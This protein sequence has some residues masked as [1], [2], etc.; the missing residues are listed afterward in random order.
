VAQIGGTMG[1]LATMGVPS[2]IVTPDK[3]GEGFAAPQPDLAWNLPVPSHTVVN[4]DLP[5]LIVIKATQ[6]WHD[7]TLR[8]RL[9]KAGQKVVDGRGIRRI[10]QALKEHLS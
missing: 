5:K 7:T 10:S 1:E 8:E 9:A 3:E 4:A 6:L 2:I